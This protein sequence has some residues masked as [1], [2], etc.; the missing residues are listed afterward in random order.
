MS[1]GTAGKYQS[2]TCWARGGAVNRAGREIGISS[3][4]ADQLAGHLQLQIKQELLSKPSH[5]HVVADK[6]GCAS[7]LQDSP[8]PVS[9]SKFEA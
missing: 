9:E 5:D 2:C 4:P 7:N 3:F 8:G 6:S 1:V